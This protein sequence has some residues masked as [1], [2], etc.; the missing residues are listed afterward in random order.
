MALQAAFRASVRNGDATLETIMETNDL[1]QI[2]Y[3]GAAFAKV[4][5]EHSSNL[6]RGPAAKW[7]RPTMSRLD[8]R[9]MEG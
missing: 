3:D 8:A 2:G 9:P 6:S 7:Q 1:A 5:R 4:A